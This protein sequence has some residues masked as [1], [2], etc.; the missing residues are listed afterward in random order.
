MTVT[1]VFGNRCF[2]MLTDLLAMNARSDEGFSH[3]NL[4]LCIFLGWKLM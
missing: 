2:Q 3:M 1:V 4:V